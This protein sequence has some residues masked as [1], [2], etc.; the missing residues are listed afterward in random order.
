MKGF[1]WRKVS[2][3]KIALPSDV[4]GRLSYKGIGLEVLSLSY[5][6]LP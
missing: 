4:A 6:I 1:W 5:Q 3:N 2:I